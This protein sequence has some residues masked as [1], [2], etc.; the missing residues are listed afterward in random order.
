MVILPQAYFEAF[1]R[2]FTYLALCFTNKLPFNIT[3]LTNLKSLEKELKKLHF[4]F[5]NESIEQ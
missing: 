2:F 3:N 4:S 1:K 5:V